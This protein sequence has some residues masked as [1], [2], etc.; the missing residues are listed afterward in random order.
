MQMSWSSL[1]SRT[2]AVAV[3][4]QLLPM[5]ASV[6]Q[7]SA[8]PAP[9]AESA[10]V[11]AG[12]RYRGSSFERWLD[13]TRYR[14]LWTTPIRVPVLDLQT[15]DGGLRPTKEG[16]GHQT[17][18]VRFE[19]PAGDEWVF[20]LID[21]T[22]TGAPV[23]LRST[24]IGQLFQDGVSAMHP[25][26]AELASPIEEAAGVLHPT[27]HMVV[28]PDDSTL[29]KFRKDFA[30]R[31]GEIEE[32]PNVPKGEG[33]GFAG[34]RK[35]VDS[36]ELLKMINTEPKE[37]IDARAYLTARLV[38]LI[39][40]DNDRG[41]G[42]QWKWALLDTGSKTRWE[43]IAR[44]RDHAF[45]SYEGFVSR[46]GALAR[47]SL[48]PFTG[49]PNVAGLTVPADL[50]QRLLSGL[51]RPVWDSVAHALQARVTDSVL[52]AAVRTMPA[53]YQSSAPYMK[54]VL[55]QRRDA[56]AR[57]A[58][59]FYHRLAGRVEVHAT[60]APDR[61]TIE[62]VDDR[63][64]KVEL[65]SGGKTYYTRRFDA[66]ETR[67]ILVYLHGSDDTAVVTG[68]VDESILVRVIGG[69]GDNV[70]V[71]SSTVGGEGHP[72][73][74]YDVGPTSGI[75]YGPDTIFE[76]RPWERRDGHLEP[77]LP[78]F[79]DAFRGDVGLS[80]DRTLGLTPRISLSRYAYGFWH[81]P[82][83]TKLRL[84]AA[85][86]PSFGGARV[87][88]LLDHRFEASPLYISLFGQMS[89]LQFVNFHGFGNATVDSLRPDSFFETHERQWQLNPTVGLAIA[90]WTD[91]TF[92]PVL[93]HSVT[94]SARSPLLASVHPYGFG[95]FDQAGLQLRARYEW[96]PAP[97]DTAHRRDRALVDL[98]GLYFPAMLD[99]R[100]PFQEA[101]LALGASVEL[102]IPLR[103]VFV[104][105]GGAKKLYG[106]FPF[107]EA[108]TIGG[109][110]TTRFMDT[111]RYAGDASLY[112]TSELLVPL[113]HFKLLIPVRAGV[114]GAAEAGRVYVGGASPGG[115]HATT[116]GGV[117]LG[118][119]YGSQVISLIGTNEPG[120]P[121][122]QLRLGLGF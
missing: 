30:G 103:P 61:A 112:G 22:A 31:L 1:P 20:R 13:G 26:A 41:T 115:W 15:F 78:D 86:A 114:M 33:P 21:K 59:D 80:D 71:D 74:L 76:R 96:L 51:E 120:R 43:P 118:R 73:R 46:I 93:Q 100:S 14:G 90:P 36:D 104:A 2:L 111:Q 10:T 40:N 110:G 95:S 29:G 81:R 45:V 4:V 121:G 34:A 53:E 37:R 27:G 56:I 83:D 70:V 72:T 77:P 6:A 9:R 28:M 19:N 87:G 57:A 102:P 5:A 23:E 8:P 92:G 63:H 98:R 106:D 38:D 60:D 85:Y 89:D 91:I 68:H 99:V 107:Y 3:A 25:A 52:D 82:F 109:L 16:G 62:R 54:R 11:V 119:V 105:R 42:D 122:L 17:K 58:G 69:N 97:E 24:P 117:W 79:G 94:D 66:G 48:V 49:T 18:N 88:V 65:E 55:A 64:V 44:D 50:D 101:S 113:A 32:Y 47:A 67:E 7:P 39:I 116:G 35:I 108:A 12:P 84:D 75:T